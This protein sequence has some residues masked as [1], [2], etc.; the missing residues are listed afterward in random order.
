MTTLFRSQSAKLRIP[1]HEGQEVKIEFAHM[2]RVVKADADKYA[3]V[4]SVCIID[5]LKLRQCARGPYYL[6]K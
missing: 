5:I 4:M 3:R 6:T 2:R 1:H